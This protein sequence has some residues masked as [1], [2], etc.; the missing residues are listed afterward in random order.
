MTF[1][2]LVTY[3]TLSN[4]YFLRFGNFCAN[5]GDNDD[6][7]KTDYFIPCVCARGNNIASY[8]MI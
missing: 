4:A 6:D 3:S 7:D 2:P 1:C 5:D 8:Y